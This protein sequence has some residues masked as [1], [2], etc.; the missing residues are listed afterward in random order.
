MEESRTT[1]GE[2]FFSIPRGP[3]TIYGAVHAEGSGMVV[4]GGAGGD[5]M[6]WAGSPEGGKH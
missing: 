2:A 1:T 4:V 5:E 3:G 6:S